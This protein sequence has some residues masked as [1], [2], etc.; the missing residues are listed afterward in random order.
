M[1]IC[2]ASPS[3]D[4]YS[5]T[6]IR[7]HIE[8][9][10]GRVVAIYGGWPMWTF[11]DRALIPPPVRFAM[12]YSG[13][14]A[15]G[16]PAAARRIAFGRLASFFHSHRVDVVLAEYG[17]TAAELVDPCLRAG[18]PLVAHF[19]GNDAYSR[20]F[21]AGGPEA[22]RRLFESAS[23]VIA[24]SRDMERQLLRLGSPREKLFYAPYGV[25]PERFA[26]VDAAANAPVFLAV[27]RF[28]DKKAPYLTLLAFREVAAAV[29]GARLE[30]AGEGPLLECCRQMSQAL[31]LAEQVVFHGRL[32]HEETAQ[33]LRTARAFVQHSLVTTGGE[34]EG[35]PVAVLEAGATALPVIA[36][37]HGGIPEAVLHG[38]TGLLVEERDV[39]GMAAAMLRLAR[40]P[41]LA[42][43]LGQSAR[44]HIIAQYR[45]DLALERLRQVLENAV[46]STRRE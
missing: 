23:A 35:T 12:K 19:H 41:A 13:R 40:D 11:Q 42:G 8:R 18:V 6:F 14:I 31:G 7:A 33:R 21:T 10:P 44:R 38:E 37:R 17:T 30:F 25:D 2:V 9:L 3:R 4:V 29:P 16:F 15:A 39:A 43:V 20:E 24:V 36:T 34:A 28:V 1:N 26:P 46:A 32:S 27:G 22:Y 5:E 45:L